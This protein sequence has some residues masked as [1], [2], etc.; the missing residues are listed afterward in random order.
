M[1]ESWGLM[2]RLQTLQAAR[3]V[4]ANLVVFSHLLSVEAKYTGGGV[5]PASALY[6]MAGV[7]LFFV[8]SG[9]IMVA[10]AGVSVRPAEFLW[11]RIV[12]IYPSY[13]LVS[14]AVLAVTFI[15]PQI[16]NSSVEGPISVWRSFLL[17]PAPTVPLLAVGWTLVHEMYFYIVFAILLLLRL[18][19]LAGLLVWATVLVVV[20]LLAPDQVSAFPVLHVMTSPLTAEFMMGAL[21]GVLWRRRCTA[22]AT[23]AS[24][25]GAAALAL[26]IFYIAPTIPLVTNPQFELWRVAIFCIP[27]TLVIYGLAGIESLYHVKPWPLL[28]LIGDSSYAVYLLHVLVLSTIGRA[29]AFFSP[30]GSIGISVVLIVT[31]WVAANVA[32]ILFHFLFERPTLRWLHQVS[33]PYFRPITTTANTE[34][35]TVL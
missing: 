22:G 23:T 10:V 11:R 17:V 32:G 9:F 6:G 8:L 35:A 13:W 2:P 19:T 25:V 30:F 14:L 1:V 27:C 15:A 21:I 4:A 16:V 12:R 20:T 31:G 3:A 33:L 28:V 29:I 7:D 26:S 24:I 34:A 18:P 5:L